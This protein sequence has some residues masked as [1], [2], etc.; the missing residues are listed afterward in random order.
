[1]ALIYALVRECLTDVKDPA[2]FWQIE[3]GNVLINK[4]P[5]GTYS[6][7]CRVDCGTPS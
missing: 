5:A 2:G 3:G 1:M 7:V 6:S 4:E